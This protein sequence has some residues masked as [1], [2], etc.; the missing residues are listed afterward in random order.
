M[1]DNMFQVSNLIAKTIT[2]FNTGLS[3]VFSTA[4]QDYVEE[5]SGAIYQTGGTINVKIPGYPTV[6]RGLSVTASAIQD[7]VV[8]LTVSAN[9]IYS[10]TRQLSI[11]ELK[12]DVVGSYGAFTED[13]EKR[14]VDNYAF[15]VFESLHASIEKEVAYKFKTSAWYSPIDTV[16]ALGGLNNFKDVESIDTLMTNLMLPQDRTL[17]SNT[18][19]AASV[20]SSLY[21]SFNSSMNENVLKQAWVGGS[22]ERGR[23]ANLDYIRSSVFSVHEAGPLAGD[24][25]LTIASV[26]SDGTSITI[27]GAPSLTSKLVNAGDRISIPSITWL[28]PIT[29]NVLST[30]V[31]VAAAEDANGDGAG[32]VTITLKYPLLASG[33]HANVSA[34]PAPGNKVY[35]FPDYKLNFAYTKSGLTA[36]PLMMD[37][38]YGAENINL[39]SDMKVPVKVWIQGQILNATSVI[40]TAQMVGTE[41]FTPYVVAYPTAV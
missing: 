38:V 11:R 1:A 36:V 21:N 9:D 6:E 16:E 5:F 40:R 13:V 23:L 3:W 22:A 24:T 39:T 20:S 7:L 17:V 18:N 10:V 34:L 8:P 32:N 27:T 14:I 28:Q 30:K 12:L 2:E 31:V 26:S 4:N 35:V 33:E 41:V 15:P 19:D 25:G 37:D 29:F